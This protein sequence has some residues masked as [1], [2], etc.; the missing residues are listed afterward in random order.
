MIA[1]QLSECLLTCIE[2]EVQQ[3]FD[4]LMVKYKLK[5]NIQQGIKKPNQVG[6][7]NVGE[8]RPKDTLSMQYRKRKEQQSLA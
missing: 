1:D 4:E 3:S 6:V 8:M 7:Q 2:A 5:G